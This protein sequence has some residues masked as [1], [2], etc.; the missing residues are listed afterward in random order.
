MNEDNVVYTQWNIIQP[1]FLK[2]G[3]VLALTAWTDLEDI[4][5][6]EMPVT[7]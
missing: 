3:K 6:S 2:K 5:P 4:T 1:F 7:E